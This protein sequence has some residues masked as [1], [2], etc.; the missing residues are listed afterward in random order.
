MKIKRIINILAAHKIGPK[1]PLKM[2]KASSGSHTMR[3]LCGVTSGH[4][5]LSLLLWISRVGACLSS[6]TAEAPALDIYNSMFQLPKMYTTYFLHSFFIEF[7]FFLLPNGSRLGPLDH[8][9]FW[10]SQLHGENF[11]KYKSDIF[12][13]LQLRTYHPEPNTLW[14]DFF[15]ESYM[16][17]AWLRTCLRTE[18]A[19]EQGSG[20]SVPEF[21]ASTDTA[22]PHGAEQHVLVL[23]FPPIPVIFWVQKE[24]SK[25]DSLPKKGGEMCL[26]TQLFSYLS[27]HAL[28]QPTEPPSPFCLSHLDLHFVYY[29][30]HPGAAVAQIWPEQMCL[31][32][33]LYLPGWPGVFVM[34]R[35]LSGV[36]LETWKNCV[37]PIKTHIQRGRIYLTGWWK[38]WLLSTLVYKKIF[39]GLDDF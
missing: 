12:I 11:K 7:F 31:Q 5:T 15:L 37:F 14:E 30:Q 23:F 2:A 35:F 4:R 26:F 9:A 16:P 3:S 28:Q 10:S 18:Q 24:K 33:D 38:F 39:P 32:R 6:I 8:I 22:L 19:S 25:A 36:F 20:V 29:I 34:Q 1:Q 17:C 21:Q 13:H 27:K